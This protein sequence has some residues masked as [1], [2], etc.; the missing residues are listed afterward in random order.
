MKATTLGTVRT[1]GITTTI[2]IYFEAKNT[3]FTTRLSIFTAEA[4]T[5]R[6]FVEF[7]LTC[8]IS[9]YFYYI[10]LVESKN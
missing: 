6:T 8:G 7:S 5:I 10:N 4:E 2:F 9:S 3:F 1:I